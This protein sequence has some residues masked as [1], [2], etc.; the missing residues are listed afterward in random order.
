MVLCSLKR[1]QWNQNTV[2][3]LYCLYL[4]LPKPT[5]LEGL[6]RPEGQIK[7][8]RDGLEKSVLWQS[9]PLPPEMKF[10]VPSSPT[11]FRDFLGSL[12]Y[13]AHCN[14]LALSWWKVGILKVCPP[15]PWLWNASPGSVCPAASGGQGQVWPG[16][17]QKL[18]VLVIAQSSQCN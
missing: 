12:S 18:S 6:C 7:I 4:H 5:S 1:Q 8:A 10:W 11:N 17:L 14:L 2:N 13:N 15:F 16:Q 9:Q 3:R